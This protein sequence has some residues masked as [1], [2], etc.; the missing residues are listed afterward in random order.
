MIMERDGAGPKDGVFIP[1][2]HGFVLPNLRPAPHERGKFLTPSPPFGALRS[3]APS[4]KTLLFVNFSYN[5]SNF[6]NETYF[7]NKNIFEITTKFIPSN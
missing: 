7:I 1:T 3:P 6:F 5:Y 2:L 4:R